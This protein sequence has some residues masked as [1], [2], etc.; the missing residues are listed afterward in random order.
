MLRGALFDVFF[1]LN[2]LLLDVAGGHK[3]NLCD[4]SHK[5]NLVNMH[6]EGVCLKWRKL[7]VFP[8]I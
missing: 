2:L 5:L 6:G 1:F 8:F 3:T 4:V 7:E